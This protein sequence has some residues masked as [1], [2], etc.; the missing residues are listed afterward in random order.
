[1]EVLPKE[2]HK[3]EETSSNTIVTTPNIKSIPKESIIFPMTPEHEKVILKELLGNFS[4]QTGA[5][6]G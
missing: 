4:D 3:E 6:F 2:T 1:M 5:C